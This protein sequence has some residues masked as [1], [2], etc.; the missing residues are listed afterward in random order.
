MFCDFRFVVLGVWGLVREVALVVR[1]DG[2]NERGASMSMH[3]DM[4]VDE[5]VSTA[6]D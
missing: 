1:G 4:P 6:R 3:D 5:M 2:R